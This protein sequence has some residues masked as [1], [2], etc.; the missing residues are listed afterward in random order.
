V[1]IC[2]PGYLEYPWAIETFTRL[3]KVGAKVKVIDLS[4]IATGYAMRI[5]FGPIRFPSITRPIL[6]RILLERSSRIEEVTQSICSN[7][8]VEYKKYQTYLK[9]FNFRRKVKLGKFIGLRWSNIDAFRILQSVFSSYQ[10]RALEKED[11]IEYQ[12][13]VHVRSA[14][15]KTYKLISDIKVGTYSTAFVVNGRQPVQAAVTL[16]LRDRNIPVILCEA[17]GGYIF[18]KLL[19]KRI[20]Y[21]FT[22]P[23][24][25]FEVQGK[26]LCKHSTFPK[27]QKLTEEN[28]IDL[29]LKR[30]DIPFTLNFLNEKVKF[31][32]KHLSQGRNYAFF[33]TS[34]WETSIIDNHESFRNKGSLFINQISAIR[35]IIRNLATNDKLFIRLHPQ[36]P[37]KYS[38]EERVWSQFK[39][40]EKVHFI[41]SFS[42]LDSY[43]LATYMDANFVWLSFLGYELTLRNIPVAVLGNSVYA[44]LLGDNWIKSPSELISW[45]KNPRLCSN[46]NLA[47]YTSY[48]AFGGFEIDS[49]QTDEF[50]NVSVNEIKTDEPKRI[51]SKLPKKIFKSIS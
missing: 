12:K 43:D 4:N 32:P 28:L 45:M 44:H 36:D 18:P 21:F 42:Q 30:E 23:A 16:T 9:P 13:A 47:K 2:G 25:A 37:G 39:Y 26:I 40:E 3:N 50:R 51:F 6:R 24:N 7:L 8:G 5:K 31:N 48:L 22:S 33:T 17:A 14:I 29:I 41:D 35:A 27:H 49:S 20:D 38:L 46:L 15:N 11:K 34:G 10:S 1:F 19:K